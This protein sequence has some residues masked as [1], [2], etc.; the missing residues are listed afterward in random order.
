MQ[1]SSLSYSASVSKM[2]RY[3]AGGQ[4]LADV[5][6]VRMFLSWSAYCGP[7]CAMGF[8]KSREVVVSNDGT[9]LAVSGDGT[10]GVEVSRTRDANEMHHAG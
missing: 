8:N 4:E 6:V 5:Y 9:V 3:A 1:G 2:D 7:L 10:P